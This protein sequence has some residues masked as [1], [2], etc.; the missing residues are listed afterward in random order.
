MSEHP[1]YANVIN[2]VK[3]D[4]MIETVAGAAVLPN[5]CHHRH[6]ACI[7]PNYVA[8]GPD[9]A[10]YI[11]EMTRLRRV[12]N[13]IIE[14]VV[15][16]GVCGYNGDEKPATEAQLCGLMRVAVGSDGSLY[17]A[18]NYNHRV[19]RVAPG[20]RITTVAGT[21]VAGFSGDGGPATLA[22][23]NNPSGVAVGPDGSLYIADTNN[24]RI[25][26][27]GPDGI[28]RTVAGNG[29]NPGYPNPAEGVLPTETAINNPSFVAVGPDGS[30]YLG[31]ESGR[32][33]RVG[34]DGLITTA[35]GDGT[36]P[37]FNG[38]RLPATRAHIYPN[39]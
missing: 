34:P 4:G 2:R 3:P 13:G 6:E 12:A 11:S 20:G 21:G 38:D 33:R 28:I 25:R 39:R 5:G 16:T 17:L 32:V 30:F 24:F 37:S 19:R 9:D 23:V 22:R 1:P 7:F 31:P 18:D 26:R 29:G 8:V 36:W 35:A 14:T 15:G 10:I 27:V